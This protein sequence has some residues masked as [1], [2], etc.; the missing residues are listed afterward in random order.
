MFDLEALAGGGAVRP[1]DVVLPWIAGFAAALAIFPALLQQD[2]PE[3]REPLA[4]LYA[5]FDADDLEDAD[6]LRPLIDAIE[7]PDSVAEAVE[8]LV[9]CTLLLADV[10]RPRPS[11]PPGRGQRRG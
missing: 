9:R 11:T 2:G 10:S 4:V 8:D 7:P 1:A 6:D 3:L 5:Y